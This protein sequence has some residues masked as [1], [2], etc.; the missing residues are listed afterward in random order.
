MANGTCQIRVWSACYTPLLYDYF[1]SLSLIFG[2][3][4]CTLAAA[5]SSEPNLKNSIRNFEKLQKPA[6]QLNAVPLLK[7][8]T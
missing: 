7:N 4:L 8:N 5:L 3:H 2:Q 1:T 6:L